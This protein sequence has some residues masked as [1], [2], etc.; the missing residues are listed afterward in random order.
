MKI[1][2][3][4]VM[5]VLLAGAGFSRAD[6]ISNSIA[7]D[8][9]LVMTCYTY[10]FLKTG[11]HAFQLS[12]DGSHNLWDYGHI[13]GDIITDSEEDPTLALFNEIDNDTGV[14]WGDYHVKVTL[15]KAFTFSNVGVGVGNPGWTF[16]TNAPVHIG[17]DWI[18]YIDYYAG[19]PVLAGGTLDFNYSMTF[20]GGASFQEELMPSTVP[21]PGTFAL[22]VCG[23]TGLLVMRRGKSI[24][25]KT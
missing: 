2:T 13:Q 4:A 11:D 21:E 9:D 5:A 12:I 6:I 7:A 15:S 19:T 22:M 18:G 20:I 23:L 16:T 1:R 3:L 17:S 8:G 25:F 14:T 10:G 24:K